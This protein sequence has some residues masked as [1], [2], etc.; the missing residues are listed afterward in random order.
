MVP[1]GRAAGSQSLVELYGCPWH[2]RDRRGS[3]S[4]V[5]FCA[6]FLLDCPQELLTALFW[7]EGIPSMPQLPYP[8][9]SLGYLE[10]RSS[11]WVGAFTCREELKS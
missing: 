3:S 11:V 7:D 5:S 2:L 9:A 4:L 1:S 8:L 6:G 10:F